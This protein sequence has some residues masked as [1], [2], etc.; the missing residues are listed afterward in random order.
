MSL[1][2]LFFVSIDLIGLLFLAVYLRRLSSR[3]HG[4]HP[5]AKPHDF[6]TED[7]AA[8][9]YKDVDMLKIIPSRPTHEGYAVVGGSGFL[10]T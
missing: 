2:Y 6:H 9:S 3:L 8:V 10:G 4:P 1:Y 5:A 7:L